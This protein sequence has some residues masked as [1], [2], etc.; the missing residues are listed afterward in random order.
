MKKVSLFLAG[1]FCVLVFAGCNG[2][3]LPAVQEMGDC[4]VPLKEIVVQDPHRSPMTYKLSIPEQWN[5]GTPTSHQMIIGFPDISNN[6]HFLSD[7]PAYL[8]IQNYLD[9]ANAGSR[10]AHKQLFSGDIEG[11][12]AWLNEDAAQS[13]APYNYQGKYSDVKCTGVY[14]G[15]HGKIYVVE[16]TNTYEDSSGVSTYRIRNYY[17]DDITY[18][19][20]VTLESDRAEITQERP[21]DP[22]DVA[23]W[24]IDSFEID[25]QRESEKK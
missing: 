14:Q 16:Y 22:E 17:R 6:P 10:N 25:V 13:P 2:A 9:G 12:T 7:I 15:T 3:N 4:S 18:Y 1:L 19:A 5:C 21:F 8:R 11:F 24:L 20:M 23:L